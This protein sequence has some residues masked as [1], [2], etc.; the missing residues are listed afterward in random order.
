M[1]KLNAFTSE[2]IKAFEPEAKVGLVATVNPEGL[3]HLTFISSIRAKT[4]TR[5]IWGQFTQGLSKKHV[6]SNPKTG[7]LVLTIDKRLWRGKAVWTHKETT[8]EDYELYNNQPMFRYN[9]YFGINTVHYM[10]LVETY[11]QE[12]LPMARII[13]SAVLTKTAKSGARS[14]VDDQIMTPWAEGLFNNLGTLK[15]ITYIGRDGFPV[16]IPLVQ[17]QAPDSRTLAFSPQ[18]YGPELSSIEKDQEV[19]VFGLDMNQMSDVLVRGRFA[20]YQRSL[21]VRLGR[22]DLDWVYNSMPPKQG[23]IYPRAKLQ[24]VVN[25]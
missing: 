22:I 2:D 6:L 10:D 11:G 7:F 23:Q 24:P 18:A 20:G 13:L 8:G 9:A 25:F 4:P 17:C 19:A 12:K 16:I 21:S 14:N 3:P 5:L 15:F 1:R